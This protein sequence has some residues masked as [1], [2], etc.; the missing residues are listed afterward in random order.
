MFDIA[1]EAN[2]EPRSDEKVDVLGLKQGSNVWLNIFPG[3]A[4]AA[5]GVQLTQEQPIVAGRN[6]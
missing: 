1:A 4:H 3:K 6:A 2:R 5:L